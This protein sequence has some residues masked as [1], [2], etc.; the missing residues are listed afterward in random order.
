MKG[1]YDI[2]KQQAKTSF[3]WAIIISFIGIVLIAFAIISPLIPVFQNQNILIPVIGS[4]GGAVV[5]L[6]AGTI[7][8]VYIKSLSQMNLYHKALSEYQRYLSCVNLVSKIS[9]IQKQDQLYEEIIHE[10]IKKAEAIDSKDISYLKNWI[11]NQNKK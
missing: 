6:F 8:V 11:I 5:E 10:E 2:S 7:L 3:A 9:T 4:I 1:Y